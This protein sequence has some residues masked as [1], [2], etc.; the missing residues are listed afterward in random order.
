M[1][2]TTKKEAIMIIVQYRDGDNDVYV[3]PSRKFGE[4][5]RQYLEPNMNFELLKSL[6]S[7]LDND[8]EETPNQYNKRIDKVD[9]LF[10]KYR[11]DTD[12]SNSVDVDYYIT[13]CYIMNYE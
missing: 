11:K 9:K 3:F 5:F 2:K 13:K 4:E 10:S 7:S 1:S 6:Y 12:K 8:V